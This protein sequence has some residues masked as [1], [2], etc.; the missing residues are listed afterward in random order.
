MNKAFFR[1]FEKRSAA[2]HGGRAEGRP[3]SRYPKGELR[4]G[5]QHEREHTDEPPVAKQIAK[6]HLEEDRHY[7]E[8]LRKAKLAFWRGFEKRSKADEPSTIADWIAE[9][10]AEQVK[11]KDKPPVRVDARDLSEWRGPEAFFRSYP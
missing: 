6:D 3:D 8:H 7:Y 11:A 9:D 1:G 2:L 5:A 4:E 10:K